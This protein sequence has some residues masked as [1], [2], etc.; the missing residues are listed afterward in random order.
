M[1]YV[2]FYKCANNTKSSYLIKLQ[3]KNDT[4]G[5]C[6]FIQNRNTFKVPALDKTSDE[7]L[8]LQYH[9]KVP[10]SDEKWNSYSK[11]GNEATYA[12]H[13]LVLQTYR[14]GCTC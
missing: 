4:G 13:V 5:L 8:R 11:I 7:D 6:V 2:T 14:R 3:R 1:A 9:S 10:K 12:H